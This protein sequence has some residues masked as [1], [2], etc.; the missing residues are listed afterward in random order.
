[1]AIIGK[2]RSKS[3]LAVGVVGGALI[4]FILADS[5]KDF[6]IPA[7]E[8]VIHATVYGEPVDMQKVNDTEQIFLRNA[9]M[10]AQ[11]SGRKM[12]DD[13]RDRVREQAFQEEVR[14]VIMT[15]QL[16]LL[17]IEV[18]SEELNF[19]VKG[20]GTLP[21]DQ[22]IQSIF[23]DSLGQ[24]SQQALNN[25]LTQ[26]LPNLE[27]EG[28]KQWADIEKSLKDG[29]MT[30]KYVSLIS[31]SMYVT[32]LEAKRAYKTKNTFKTIQFVLKRYNEAMQDSANEVTD[33]E[34]KAFYEEHKNEKKYEQKLARKFAYVQIPFSPSE[35]DYD[36]YTRSMERLKKALMK[37]T[38]DSSFVVKNSDS[39]AYSP[40]A[41]YTVAP[42]SPQQ[43][44]TY[45]AEVSDL[46]DSAQIGD[47]V[48][49]YRYGPTVC[50]AKK[51]GMKEQKLAWVRHILIKIEEPNGRSEADAKSLSDSIMTVIRAN[52]NFVEMVQK[53]SEDQGSVYNGGEY[54]WFPEGQ[55]VP[56][57]NDASFNGAIG[58]LQL[59]KTT[60]GY[61]IVEVLGRKDKSPVL[62]I[63]Q[64]KVKAGDAANEAAFDKSL[65]LMNSLYKKSQEE[66][67]NIS[68]DS[69]YV[70]K[71]GY[72]N[73]ENPRLFGIEKGQESIRKFLFSSSQNTLD[74]SSPIL[75]DEGV[76]AIFQ[77]IDQ[78]EEGV[79][80]FETVKEQMR[81]EAKKAKVAKMYQEQL[82]GK[83]N[84]EEVATAA[85][86]DIQ[87]AK[88]SFDSPNIQG[89]GGNEPKIVGSIFAGLKQGQMTV[90]L[91]GNAGI[92]VILVTGTIEAQE[93]SD[94]S[95]VK[96]EL[97]STLRDKEK[98]SGK[99]YQ[100][101]YDQADVEDNR[102][103]IKYGAQ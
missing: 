31:K 79:P 58:S 96:N 98:V 17:G 87:T 95:E 75:I 69:G 36:R 35:A 18:N 91:E 86:V 4:L 94:Y 100:G 37:T 12:T 40:N 38:N 8:Q 49:P 64:K 74:I 11:Q 45:P 26:T 90:P 68:K 44:N 23:R 19:L 20:D 28:K 24:F 60:F 50:I 82:S 34:I 46:I 103:K 27:P 93:T 6:F 43:S 2:I 80:S 29:R 71:D 15:K 83:S 99:V 92:Y 56:E 63:V 70:V 73:I 14:K 47:V 39:K 30:D 84:L 3:G 78:I 61:H 52:D 85:G 22:Y 7:P 53:F 1:M 54:K 81:F 101:L 76:Y 67:L 13:D 33:A 41:N 57:F 97:Q 21:P 32:D 65:A 51:V 42:Y 48:G 72:V 66:F 5:F 55:M 62:A 88:V 10:Q 102:K 59:V 25:F 9:E 89:A 16:G 77:I